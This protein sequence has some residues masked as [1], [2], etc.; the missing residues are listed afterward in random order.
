MSENRRK[1]RKEER[2]KPQNNIDKKDK[3]YGILAIVL[4]FLIATILVII[5]AFS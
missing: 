3:I 1:R 4:L 5:N 2:K